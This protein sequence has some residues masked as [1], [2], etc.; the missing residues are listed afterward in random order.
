ME[1]HAISPS[2]AGGWIGTKTVMFSKT[3]W[4]VRHWFLEDC[5][6]PFWG[7][8][9]DMLAFLMFCL[10]SV[11]L[12]RTHGDGEG[13]GGWGFGGPTQSSTPFFHFLTY[14][15][16][17]WLHGWARLLHLEVLPIP[18]LVQGMVERQKTMTSDRIGMALPKSPCNTCATKS[19]W[20]ILAPAESLSVAI[21]IFHF[22]LWLPQNQSCSF[23]QMVPLVRFCLIYKI[24]GST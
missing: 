7:T 12:Q 3:R 2:L 9:W 11:R 15:G 19:V 14:P 5:F 20:H 16:L 4:Q 10:T 1:L 21:Y 8:Q 22:P 17:R 24:L 23:P 18:G 13:D 6:C